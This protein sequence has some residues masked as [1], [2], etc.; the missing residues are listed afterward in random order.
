MAIL[1]LNIPE[2]KELRVANALAGNHKIP[3]DDNGNP[4]FTKAQ[5][6]HECVKRWLISEVEMWERDQAG[7]AVTRDNALI[8]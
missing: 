7:K 6:V 5:W 2:S 1:T 4:L 3:L 8:S